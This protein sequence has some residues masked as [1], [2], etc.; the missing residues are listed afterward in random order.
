MISCVNKAIEPISFNYEDKEIALE[1]LFDSFDKKN[2]IYRGNLTLIN[3][4]DKKIV[5]ARSDL[6]ICIKDKGNNRIYPISIDTIASVA[7]YAEPKTKSNY[8][9]FLKAKDEI[10]KEKSEI[11]VVSRIFKSSIED[12]QKSLSECN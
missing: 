8:K 10:F 6:K 1:I 11:S 7:Y 12:L 4:S 2:S 5:A 3:L 9:I